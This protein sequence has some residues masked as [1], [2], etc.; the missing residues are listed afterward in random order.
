MTYDEV[1]QFLEDNYNKSI[2]IDFKEYGC[3]SYNN[4]TLL[5]E[6]Q[7]CEV[8]TYIKGNEVITME[9]VY[10]YYGEEA[11]INYKDYLIYPYIRLIISE[12][13]EIS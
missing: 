3:I 11:L 1:K 9:D 8:I 7:G 6:I 5:L 4:P 10:K 13:L 12:P 2:K